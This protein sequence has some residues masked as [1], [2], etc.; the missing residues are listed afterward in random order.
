MSLL[1]N[2]TTTNIDTTTA[3]TTNRIIDSIIYIHVKRRL[4]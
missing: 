4:Y 3:D 1:V 2:N